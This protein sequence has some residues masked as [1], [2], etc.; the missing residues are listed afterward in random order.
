MIG[1]TL[2]GLEDGILIPIG[3]LDLCRDP[4]EKLVTLTIN[5]LMLHMEW[6]KS[7]TASMLVHSFTAILGR[8]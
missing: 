6:K 8:R 1:A 5:V 2:G 7:T 3:F 4:T